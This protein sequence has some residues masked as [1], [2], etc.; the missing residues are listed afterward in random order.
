MLS[1]VT[2]LPSR[3]NHAGRGRGRGKHFDFI[4][5]AHPSHLPSRLPPFGMWEL[6][7]TPGNL[8]ARFSGGREKRAGAACVDIVY[9]QDESFQV[10][11][12]RRVGAYK[13]DY[14]S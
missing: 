4:L 13:T 11:D 6:V 9:S 2:P 1:A 10:T 12:V 8:P 3:P 7:P 5:L 14:I